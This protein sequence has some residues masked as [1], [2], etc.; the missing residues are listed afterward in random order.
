MAFSI[1]AIQLRDASFVVQGEVSDFDYLTLVPRFDEVGYWE[2]KVP[3]SDN[4][5]SPAQ[6]L[7]TPLWGIAVLKS[8][9]TTVLSGRR[10][11]LEHS[12]DK[13]GDYVTF[14]G[15][16]DL[17]LVGSAV[18]HPQPGSA[19]PPYSTTAYDV[20]TGVASTIIQQYVNV[21]VGPGAVAARR[22]ANLAIG[23]DPGIGSSL[24]ARGR[25]QDLLDLLQ[26]IAV[27]S[28]PVVG[29]RV[30]QVASGQVQFQ[31]Y[32]PVDRSANIKFS[33]GLGNVRAFRRKLISPQLSYAYIGG[34]GAGTARVIVEGSSAA[35]VANFGRVEQFVDRRDVADNTSGELTAEAIGQFQQNGSQQQIDFTSL[36]TAAVSY[37][38]PYNLG[39]TVTIQVDNQTIVDVIREVTITVTPDGGVVVQPLVGTYGSST[40]PTLFKT[41]DQVRQGIGHL[42][43]VQ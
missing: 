9:G 33:R 42:A 38:S 23:T 16:D 3:Y 30:A 32:Q 41:L 1:G 15:P 31:C 28:S 34:G 11:D 19:A 4:P 10:Q 26:S 13:A 22:V 43:A 25:W 14:Y 39:D 35:D 21:N 36:E 29:F 12:W 27:Q 40:G 6:L 5:K 17:F 20:R 8:D 7:Q 18:A 24:T 37:T 2:L